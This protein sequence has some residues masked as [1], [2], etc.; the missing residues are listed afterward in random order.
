MKL[1][2]FQ[3]R[4]QRAI[5]KG[6]DAILKDIPDGPR[7]TKENLL[8]IYRDAYALRLIE[9]VGKDHEMLHLYLGEDRFS[10]MARAYIASCPSNTPNARWF[11]QRLPEFLKTNEPYARRPILS[12]LALLE[13]ALNDA[14]DG[15]DVPVLRMADLAALPPQTWG[16]LSF[17]SH[18]TARRLDVH[19]NVGA[20]WA[21]LKAGNVPPAWTLSDDATQILVWRQETTSRF[22]EIGAEEAMVWAEAV[23]GSR[24]SVLCEL[25]ATYDD[26]PAAPARAAGYL[27]TWLEAGLLSEAVAP[28]K[29]ALGASA[30]GRQAPSPPARPHPSVTEAQT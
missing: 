22:R 18:P 6:D 28:P 26:A 8:G 17:V 5:L 24:F 27:K 13:R 12:E 4:F 30:A 2:T 15:A 25:L 21:A 11:S 3:D 20:I 1:K 10:A 9:V 19:T 29:A 16:E 23:S 7:E 14:F